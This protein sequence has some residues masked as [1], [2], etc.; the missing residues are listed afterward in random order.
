MKKISSVLIIASVLLFGAAC[1]KQETTQQQ[2][3][4]NQNSL[5]AGV[6]DTEEVLELANLGGVTFGRHNTSTRTA[7][8][9]SMSKTYLGIDQGMTVPMYVFGQPLPGRATTQL[10][11]NLE[12]GGLTSPVTVISAIDG[13]VGFVRQQAESND[14]EIFLQTNENSVWTIGYDHITD[15]TVKQGDRVTV[16]Q[17]LGKAARENNGVYRYELQINKDVN[18]VTTFHC[19]T[20]LLRAD[21][22]ATQVAAIEQLI[23]DWNAFYGSNAYGTYT[24]S[25]TKSVLTLDETE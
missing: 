8:D 22:K 9:F 14:S 6:G 4:V 21:V 24:T 7:G 18:G 5:A 12:F 2:Q 10:N 15:V 17:V 11:P 23:K 1:Q 16:G 13:I 25:C 19:P 20:D 3:T